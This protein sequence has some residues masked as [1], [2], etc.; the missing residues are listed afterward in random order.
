MHRFDLMH[1]ALVIFQKNTILVRFVPEPVTFKQRGS[2]PSGLELLLSFSQVFCHC[3]YFGFCHLDKTIPPATGAAL[4]ADE[5]GL[6]IVLF[7]YKAHSLEITISH[8][9]NIR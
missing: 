1:Q 6:E 7:R 9:W 4:P 3:D 5:S 2:Q 8:G